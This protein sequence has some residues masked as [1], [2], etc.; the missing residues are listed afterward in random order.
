MKK[1]RS[2][3]PNYG[4]YAI[5]TIAILFSVTEVIGLLLFSAGYYVFNNTYLTIGGVIIAAFGIYMV[6]AH[7]LSLYVFIGVD[8]SRFD[9][10]ATLLQL[11]GNEYVLDVACMHA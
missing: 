1:N 10:I 11:K 5:K 9:L 2:E 7:F 6:V 3:K 4:L 8:G